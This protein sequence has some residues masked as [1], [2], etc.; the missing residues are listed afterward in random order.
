[1]TDAV[2]GRRKDHLLGKP[3]T[4]ASKKEYKWVILDGEPNRRPCPDGTK[5][6]LTVA[7]L[8]ES[9]LRINESYYRRL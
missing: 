9:Y 6:D 8:I 3:G 1:L 2:T 7:D 5:T 4:A